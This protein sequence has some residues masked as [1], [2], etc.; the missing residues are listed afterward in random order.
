MNVLHS[1]K[2]RIIAVVILLLTVSLTV[3]S[4]LSY[5]QISSSIHE[6]VN[7]YSMLKISTTSDTILTWIDT[8]KSGL[9]SNAPDFVPDYN[10]AQILLMIRQIANTSPASDI[11]VGYEDGRSYGNNSGKRDLTKYDPRVRDWYKKA[12]QKGSTIV[13]DIYSDA[14]T[15]SLMVS[16]AEPFYSQGQLKGVLL[17]DIELGLLDELVR[18]APFPGAMMGLYDQT[19]LTIASNGEVD[20]PGETQ[21]YDFSDLNPLTD[22]LLSQSTGMM[23]YSLG[24][25]EKVAFFQTLPLDDGVSWHLLVGVNKSIAYAEVDEA[26]N[27]SLYTALTLLVVSFVIFFTILSYAYRPILAL[28]STVLDLSQGN[29]DL[30]RRLDVNT[31]DDLGQIAQAVNT[32]IG[33]L[34]TMMIEVSQSSKHISDNIEL[35]NAQTESNDQVLTSHAMETTQVVTAMNEMSSTAESV[36]QSASQTAEFTKVTNDEAEQSKQVVASAVRS[37]ADL[38]E[39]VE[40]MANSIQSMNEDSQKIGSVLTVIGEIADQTNLLAL[41]AAIEAARAGEQ[42]RG[43]AVVAD[44]VRALAARTQQSTSEIN[45]MLANLNEGTKTVVKAMDETKQ[46][47][48]KTAETTENVNES[49]DLMVSSI[50]RIN[51]LGLEIATAAEQ[52]NSVTEEVSRNMTTIQGMVDELTSNSS[53]TMASTV[54]LAQ[55]NQQLSAIVRQFKLQ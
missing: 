53:Q 29:G 37:V 43:F 52:Q 14:L 26:L 32:F 27:T 21:L 45:N 36:A 17:A 44:E 55:S 25:V 24:G 41:N 7:E 39:E 48:H 38:I 54:D 46:R 42:G 31:Q 16:V 13:T 40:A 35:L 8:I 4:F 22:A 5:R 9:V 12:K 30:T 3:S 2:G 33:N 6:R 19:S 23:D 18:K 10:D 1:F 34:Q 47:C 15:K 20:V 51:D 28:K 49:L 50:V 11:L